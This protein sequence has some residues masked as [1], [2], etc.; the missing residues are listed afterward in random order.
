MRRCEVFGATCQVE[1]VIMDQ[2]STCG[3]TVGETQEALSCDF[4]SKWEHV[5]CVRQRERPSEAL[6]QALIK[7]NIKCIMYICSC[8]RR[9]G[10]IAQRL[11][12]YEQQLARANDERL[13]SA[14]LIEER[15]A[16]IRE[17]RNQNV[18]LVAKH[19]SL[20]S[21]MLKL[22]QQLMAANHEYHENIQPWK[23]G[24]IY[25]HRFKIKESLATLYLLTI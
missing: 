5:C 1:S 25:C 17:L 22:T 12:Q 9:Q 11:F 19:T 2:C 24:A 21:D 23:F 20:Q 3:K 13:A 10:S 4:C 16:S 7:C 14:R 6:Y 18:K 15:E 8:C